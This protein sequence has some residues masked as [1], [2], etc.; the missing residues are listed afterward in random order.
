[1]DQRKASSVVRKTLS[2]IME[3][4]NNDYSPSAFATEV[5]PSATSQQSPINTYKSRKRNKIITQQ[6]TTDSSENTN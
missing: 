1:M 6:L 4:I 3:S 2:Q 5:I